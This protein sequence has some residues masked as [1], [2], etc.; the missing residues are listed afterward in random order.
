MVP[1][2]SLLTV[3]TTRKWYIKRR[4]TLTNSTGRMSRLKIVVLILLLVHSV[5]SKRRY[6]GGAS[7]SSGHSWSSDYSNSTRIVDNGEVINVIPVPVISDESKYR[8][9]K[10]L[11]NGKVIYKAINKPIITSS[12]HDQWRENTKLIHGEKLYK[13][14]PRYYP[15][16][17]GLIRRN[18]N[19]ISNHLDN[20]I[21]PYLPLKVNITLICINEE[22][23]GF[24]DL[25]YWIRDEL[26]L[27]CLVA[28]WLLVLIGVIIFLVIRKTN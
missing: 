27:K 18:W 17:L 11:I 23:Y 22:D 21:Y 7:S 25:E 20:E 12:I 28:F 15:C 13:N 14:D 24:S 26:G 4:W 1:F 6:F 3:G 8:K 16:P 2:R 5:H 9:N 19:I 10:S